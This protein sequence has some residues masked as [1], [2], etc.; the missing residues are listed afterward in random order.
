MYNLLNYEPCLSKLNRLNTKEIS[1]ESN[2]KFAPLIVS[3]FLAIRSDNTNVKLVYPN[4][5]VSISE[6]ELRY[7]LCSVLGSYHEFTYFKGFNKIELKN[8]S[9][10]LL[11][12]IKAIEYTENNQHDYLVISDSYKFSSEELHEL[13]VRTEYTSILFNKNKQ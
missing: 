1:I 3:L 2:D 12:K 13:T 9:I 7:V 5:H 6:Y 4:I 11:C 8:G 10:V